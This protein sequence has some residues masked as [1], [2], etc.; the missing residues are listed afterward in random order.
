MSA[1]AAEHEALNMGQ[2]FPGFAM[3]QSLI[4]RVHHYMS[5]GYNQ[6]SP[7]TGV[8]A[9]RDRVS[10]IIHDQ[11]GHHYDPA[12][13]ITITSGATQA[14]FTAISALVH[15]DDDLGLCSNL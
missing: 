10:Q 13:E 9:L 6:Y 7:M 3:D 8:P 11:H 12:T 14:I 15:E 5:A 2:G 4:D 1:L